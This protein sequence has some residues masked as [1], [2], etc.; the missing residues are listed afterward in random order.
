VGADEAALQGHAAQA[1][2]QRNLAFATDVQ[3]PSEDPSPTIFAPFLDM[4][5]F[6]GDCVVIA[7]RL[8]GPWQMFQRAL[9]HHSCHVLRIVKAQ[10]WYACSALEYYRGT[11][12]QRPIPYLL[13]YRRYPMFMHLSYLYILYFQD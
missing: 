11:P 12:E 13:V 8:A 7:Q 4:L 2:H 9:R 5:N 6:D 3:R 10:L 1:M